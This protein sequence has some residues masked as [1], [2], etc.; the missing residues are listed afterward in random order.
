MVVAMRDVIRNLYCDTPP[1]ADLRAAEVARAYRRHCCKAACQSN[2]L[3]YL[4]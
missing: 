3:F 1:R 4:D 2:Y